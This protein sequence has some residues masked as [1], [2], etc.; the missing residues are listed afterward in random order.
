MAV[1][2]RHVL[3]RIHGADLGDPLCGQSV[4]RG[5]VFGEWLAFLACGLSISARLPGMVPRRFVLLR[6]GDSL[7]FG[8]DALRCGARASVVILRTLSSGDG[9]QGNGDS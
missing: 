4:I 2:N 8:L 6:S 1:R 5:G 9:E 3:F 7:A